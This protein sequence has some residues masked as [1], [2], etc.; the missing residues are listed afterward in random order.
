MFRAGADYPSISTSDL[1]YVKRMVS[2]ILSE[3]VDKN[4]LRVAEHSKLRVQVDCGKD[5]GYEYRLLTIDGPPGMEV[6]ARVP[7]GCDHVMQLCLETSLKELGI[8]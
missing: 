2:Y 1:K 3:L 6:F 7:M 4:S 8:L 5:G